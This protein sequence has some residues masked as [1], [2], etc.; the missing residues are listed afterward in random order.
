MLTIMKQTMK[1]QDIENIKRSILSNAIQMDMLKEEIERRIK[2]LK[3]M[4]KE[5]QQKNK[6]KK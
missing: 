2:L 6:R 5:L 3:K 4:K 1:L